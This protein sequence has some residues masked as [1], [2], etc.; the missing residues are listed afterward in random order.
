[1]S[2]DQE[3]SAVVPTVAPGPAAAQD[4]PG[5]ARTHAED[6]GMAENADVSADA[7]EPD[8]DSSRAP[9]TGPAGE[10]PSG[11][12][13]ADA[14]GEDTAEATE[15]SATAGASAG[16]A[17]TTDASTTD[18]A[19]TPD[20]ATAAAGP[21]TGSDTAAGTTDAAG[22]PTTETAPDAADR[23]TLFGPEPAR[24]V[25]RLRRAVGGTGRFLV[26]EW[27]VVSLAAIALAVVMTWPSAW[28]PASTIPSDIWDPTLQAWQLAWSGHAML[29]DPL[30]VW[31]SNSFYPDSY[32][33]A[34]SDTLFGYFPF[35]LVGTGPT[36]ALIRYNLLF[37]LLEALAFVGAYA[38]VRQLGAR[39]TAA[40]VAGAAFAYAPW[41]WGQAG[42]MH[43]LSVGG[44]ALSL[45]MIARGHGF[46]FTKGHRR[47]L[48]RPGWAFAGWCVAAWQI[49]LGFGIGL[50]FVYVLA[51]VVIVS[52]IRWLLK[53]RRALGRRLLLADGVG[54]VVFGAVGLL[55]GVPYLEVI[56][57]HPEA[58]RGLDAIE[59]FSPNLH[60]FITAPAQS[61]PWGAA[62]AAARATMIAPAETTLLP[63]FMLYGLAAAGLF[64]SIWSLRTRL[65]LLAGTLVSIVLAEGTEFYGGGKYTYVF[66]YKYLPFFSSSR[67]PGRLVIWTTLLLAIL[68]AGAVGALVGRSYD[69]AAERGPVATRPGLLLRVATLL[70]LLLVLA[71][72]TNWHTLPHPV[73]PAQ[74]AALRTVDGPMLVLPSD[75]L[76]D[77]NVMLWSTTKFQKIV[78]GGS[79]FYP[80][81]QQEVRNVAKSF[82][83]QASV[84]YLRNL[85]IRAV[86]VLK[87]QA[88]GS[89]DYSKAASPDVPYQ[90][91]GITRQDLGD[92]FVYRL[93]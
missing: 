56:K 47:E 14:S 75:A 54:I 71:E 84:E 35:G 19:G 16:E 2:V 34:F 21:T 27:T 5:E 18:A 11:S 3:G 25:G 87:Q 91:L 36:A 90:D 77:E 42:H 57:Q 50:P 69:V 82:P 62:H 31:N 39:R 73:V 7:T 26:H 38:L 76:I 93:S 70:P 52:A 61:L 55:M 13:R 33:F 51:L 63:G 68:A 88:A 79:G 81:D 8:G 59:A 72:G 92:T 46:S 86:V 24:R 65:W 37:I 23:W 85:G 41:R 15:K 4:P 9:G 60:S 32:S 40:A 67:T 44:I 48:T 10:T 43:V 49:S 28:H 80:T 29:T 17:S 53:G 30:H 74:P 1:M 12:A 66:L 78:N 58:K 89:T 64:F 22:D 83:D 20:A 45:A 6:T